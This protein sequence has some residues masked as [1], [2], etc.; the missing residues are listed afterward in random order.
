MKTAMTQIFKVTI[1]LL[2]KIEKAR[3]RSIPKK[4]IR[5]SNS[6]SQ[7]ESSFQKESSL[8]NEDILKL[9]NF[10]DEP[11]KKRNRSPS[12]KYSRRRIMTKLKTVIPTN[13]LELSCSS[14]LSQEKSPKLGKRNYILKADIPSI[15]FH[16]PSNNPN[17]N[18]FL[19]YYKSQNMSPKEKEGTIP[20]LDE[21]NSESPYQLTNFDDLKFPFPEEKNNTNSNKSNSRGNNDEFSNNIFNQGNLMIDQK[22]NSFQQNNNRKDKEYLPLYFFDKSN[23]I[24]NNNISPITPPRKQIQFTNNNNNQFNQNQMLPNNNI[25]N[26]TINNNYI[27]QYHFQG[28][29]QDY[30]QQSIQIPPQNTMN[31]YYKPPQMNIDTFNYNQP[32]FNPNF[33]NSTQKMSKKTSFSSLSTSSQ[34]ITALPCNNEELIQRAR[35]MASDQNG[36]RFIQKK[37]E[38]EPE[39]GNDVFD[40]LEKDLLT[41]SC[42]SFGN[43][44]LQKLLCVIDSERVG[45]FV[46]IVIPFFVKVAVSSHGTRVIQKL[47][48]IIRNNNEMILKIT[49]VLNTN[50]L[51]ITM[52]ANSN[53]IIQKYVSVIP[54]PMNATVY[55]NIIKNFLL[56]S[57]D[58]YGCCMMQKCI[59]CGT[60]EQKTRLIVLALQ[61]S[62]L[63]ITDQYGNYVLQYIVKLE[64]QEIIAQ[65]INLILTNIQKYCCQK[66]SSN[67]IEKCLEKACPELQSRLIN[68]IVENEKLVSDLIVDLFGNYII[69]KILLIVKGKVYY[70]LLNQI[71]KNAERIRR[72]SFGNRVL[73]KLMSLHKDLCFILNG[74]TQPMM[75]NFNYGYNT[76]NF[77]MNNTM[78]G[79]PYNMMRGNEMNMHPMMYMNDDVSVSNV[80]MYKGN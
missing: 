17:E 75:N 78:N 21:G 13:K 53:H 51:E 69:Q 23:N 4:K 41:L 31:N 65:I 49:N 79:Y 5:K 35:E 60:N 57:K 50:L 45:R 73:A 42:G 39:T 46:D 70:F 55:E 22:L 40:S 61:N 6:N 74:N 20:S 38:N 68:A 2:F 12:Q 54:F 19:A 36:C 58:K 30:Y 48:D 1:K 37:I 67:V 16:T 7:E 59:E 18:P 25:N 72:V 52:D 29:N 47:L 43:Y 64:N 3:C 10:E 28:Q 34:G 15:K 66:F 56:I 33:Q 9:I 14:I 77:M 62:P 80:K 8:L 11:A 63:L 26:F 76:P 44:L 32:Q 27:N 24:N 71:A